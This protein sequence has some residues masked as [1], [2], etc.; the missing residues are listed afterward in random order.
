L[1][2]LERFSDRLQGL[3]LRNT[4][5]TDKGLRQ[6][7]VLGNLRLLSLRDT[8]VTDAAMIALK[9]SLPGLVINQ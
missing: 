6:I 1:A 9:Q 5:I 4:Q 3:W 7:S 2:N 8:T